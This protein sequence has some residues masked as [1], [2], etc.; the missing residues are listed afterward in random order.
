MPNV[1]LNGVYIKCNIRNKVVHV[2]YVTGRKRYTCDGCDKSI[3]PKNDY[4]YVN[5]DT[6]LTSVGNAVGVPSGATFISKRSL[7]KHYH[8]EC[9]PDRKK[10]TKLELKKAKQHFKK[11]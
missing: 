10:Y 5:V 9:F 4:Y 3:P 1:E 8:T 11:L 6:T 7:V 2:K